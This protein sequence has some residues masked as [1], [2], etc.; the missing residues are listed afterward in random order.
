MKCEKVTAGKG[1]DCIE[2]RVAELLHLGIVATYQVLDY[3]PTH[4]NS[5]I[6][7]TNWARKCWTAGYDLANR[8]ELQNTG[9]AP[10]DRR[11]APRSWLLKFSVAEGIADD[12]RISISCRACSNE[13]PVPLDQIPA[14][15]KPATTIGQL[16]KLWRS[17]EC[18]FCGLGGQRRIHVWVG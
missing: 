1:T 14:L 18:T 13:V 12:V 17:E 2:R 9:G 11:D 10:I 8:A 7:E 15:Q 16:C 5:L 6:S 3:Q 4:L